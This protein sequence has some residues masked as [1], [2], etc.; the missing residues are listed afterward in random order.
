MLSI[1]GRILKSMTDITRGSSGNRLH[2]GSRGRVGLGGI[3]YHDQNGAIHRTGAQFSYAYHIFIYNSQLSFGLT[4]SIFQYRIGDEAELKDPEN[5]PLYSLIGKSTI[6]PDAGIGINYMEERWHVGLSVSQ[7][8]QTKL[9][10]GNAEEYKLSED[11][12]L[13]RHYYMIADY[14]FSFDQNNKWEIEPSTVILAN[15][16]L[17]F[18]ADLSLK[19]YYKRQYWFGLSGRTTGEII[20]MGGIKFGNYYFGYSYDYGFS[21]ISSYTLG[22]HEIT[23]S[24]KFG[25]TSRKYNWLD[26]Y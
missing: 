13:K 22:S 23:I 20:I 19:A 24:A 4:G 26:R 3:V 17:R 6:I 11:I 12:R 10:L 15:E 1:Q 16:M 14:R 5:D 21:G 2:S 25:D 18:S 9:K 8:F 7:I